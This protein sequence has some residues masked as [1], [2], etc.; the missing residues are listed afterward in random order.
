MTLYES[1][2]LG[3][4]DDKLGK[5]F[6][7]MVIIGLGLCFWGN[8]IYTYIYTLTNDMS[9]DTYIRY[10]SYLGYNVDVEKNGIDLI[11]NISIYRYYL[12]ISIFLISLCLV[13][14]TYLTKKC[15][16]IFNGLSFG[17]IMFL[18]AIAFIA[19]TSLVFF[20]LIIILMILYK[21][22]I[23]IINLSKKLKTQVI[24]YTTKI[25]NYT[26]N[27]IIE[28]NKICKQKTEKKD[29]F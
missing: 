3:E 25:Y 26:L 8:N 22:I 9:F 19:I 15:C 6:L 17:K 12:T 21:P 11:L 29:N 14:K 7:T 13:F 27:V 28:F 4:F 5:I 1:F 10:L 23:F 2:K 16:S 24:K 18:N 20:E